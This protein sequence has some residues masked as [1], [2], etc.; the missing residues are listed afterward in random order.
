MRSCLH[1]TTESR[2]GGFAIR[3][4]M[5]HV[6][7]LKM[8][9]QESGNGSGLASGKI[10]KEFSDIQAA[11]TLFLASIN[12]AHEMNFSIIGKKVDNI[13]IEALVY[14]ISIGIVQVADGLSIFEN[15]QSIRQ[16][17]DLFF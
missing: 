7:H 14:I 6:L 13:L 11:D 8:I 2:F 17:F 10:L 5:D 16:L 9:Q 4:H 3:R 1:E 12:A 15:S